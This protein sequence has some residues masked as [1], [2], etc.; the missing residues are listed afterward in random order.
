MITQSRWRAWL[1]SLLGL[2]PLSACSP[3]EA[4]P[5]PGR[6]TLHRLNRDEYNNTVRD[7]LGTSQRPADQFPSDDIGFGFDNVAQV[8]SVS[9]PHVERYLRAAESLVDEVLRP[10]GYPLSVALKLAMWKRV[11]DE[12]ITS[13]LPRMRRCRC[14]WKFRSPAAIRSRRARLAIKLRPIQRR[15][16]LPSTEPRFAR[17]LSQRWKPVR[18]RFRLS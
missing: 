3:K 16:S 10:D 2:G 1:L 7:L 6:V 18:R 5:D 8:L 12:E 9:A 14:A 4:E 17:C 13:S 15:W 11:T